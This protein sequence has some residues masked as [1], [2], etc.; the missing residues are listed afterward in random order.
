MYILEKSATSERVYGRRFTEGDEAMSFK[1]S[2]RGLFRVGVA[3]GL[4]WGAGQLSTTPFP[5]EGATKISMRGWS[6]AADW[7]QKRVDD[8]EAEN[9]SIQVD[10]QAID[11]VRYNDQ[12]ATL[13]I[14]GTPPDVLWV[15]DDVFGS[16]IEAGYVASL[17]GHP[18]LDSLNKEMYPSVLAATKYKGVQYGLPYYTDVLLNMYNEDLMHKAGFNQPPTIWTTSRASA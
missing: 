5:A 1:I 3:S 9:P 11:T 12:A 17:E 7:F 8:F 15:R 13:F 6:F 14:A 2:R 10:Y 16:W 4:A 18:G